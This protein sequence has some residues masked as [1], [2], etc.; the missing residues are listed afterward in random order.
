MHRAT[1]TR[2]AAAAD[3]EAPQ[4][5]DDGAKR[6]LAAEDPEPAA[7]PEPEPTP[8]AE[9]DLPPTAAEVISQNTGKS[10]R[11]VQ[12]DLAL[13]EAFSEETL[14]ILSRAGASRREIIE[15]SKM[16][17]EQRSMAAAWI[18]AGMTPRAA[19]NKAVDPEG[20]I[21]AETPG[22]KPEEK[23]SDE[24]W[25]G[26][27]C[28]EANERIRAEGFK[29]Q[30]ILYRQTRELLR[31]VGI[32][33]KKLRKAAGPGPLSDLISKVLR[34]SHPKDWPF[35][36]RCSGTGTNRT[37]DGRCTTCRGHGFDIRLEDAR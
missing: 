1:R 20:Y 28:N 17:E 23:M 9:P 33:T 6:V 36:A 27:Y 37:G 21:P 16:P 32:K 35:C 26:F 25:F 31:Q 11:T 4:G 30:A 24:E 3:P 18:A 5:D 19:M 10:R 12:E 13:K 8:A 34:I 29:A 14:G 2:K 15:L 22:V 7:G